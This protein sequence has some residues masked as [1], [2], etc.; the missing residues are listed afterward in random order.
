MSHERYHNDALPSRGQL[1]AGIAGYDTDERNLHLWLHGYAMAALAGRQSLLLEALG[2]IST[3]RPRDGSDPQPIL[4]DPTTLQRIWQGKY[5]GSR[6]A[7]LAAIRRLK[8]QSDREVGSE[9]ID[10]CVTE[11]ILKTCDYVHKQRCM[12]IVAGE[13]G[14]GK[15]HA[16]KRWAMLNNHGASHYVYCHDSSAKRPLIMAIARQL[17]I[18]DTS[19][20]TEE[21]I[22]RV[23]AQLR[24][25]NTLVL[26]EAHYL[27]NEKAATAPGMSCLR[28]LHDLTGV[29]IIMVV[30]PQFEQ[31]R[32]SSRLR[33]YLAQVNRRIK[34]GGELHI[35]T[36]VGEQEARQLCQAFAAEPAAQLVELVRQ[37]ANQPD[38]GSVVHA[39]ELL[40]EARKTARA[41][42]RQEVSALDLALSIRAE[43]ADKTKGLPTS[44][45]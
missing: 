19:R 5:D 11:Q 24:P 38:S 6:G 2:N 12:G 42:G 7:M 28:T 4:M 30:T 45:N 22:D 9:W 8:D 10:T 32:E 18:R 13:S 27:L 44:S 29:A 1:E 15:T 36:F 25:H 43:Q 3:S 14:R 21:L 16:V 34:P 35:P 41:A 26:D 17:G 39:I 40:R 31:L 37:T 23:H 33:T 20:S